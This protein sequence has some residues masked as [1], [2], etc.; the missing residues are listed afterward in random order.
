MATDLLKMGAIA[1]A[2][3][4]IPGAHSAADKTME[5]SFIKF[6]KSSG[7]YSDLFNMFHAYQRFCRTTSIGVQFFEKMLEMCDKINDPECPKAGKHR[8]L[9]AAEMKKSEEAVHEPLLQY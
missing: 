3:S 8:E 2:R 4:L 9:E 7:I 5:E 1:V 6:A